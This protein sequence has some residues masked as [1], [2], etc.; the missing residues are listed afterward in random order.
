MG[1]EN[2]KKD[3]HTYIKRMRHVDVFETVCMY[4]CVHGRPPPIERLPT[5]RTTSKFLYMLQWELIFDNVAFIIF[6]KLFL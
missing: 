1:D 5:R 3:T 4:M 6:F 2:R